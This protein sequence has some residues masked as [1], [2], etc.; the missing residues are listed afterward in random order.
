[1]AQIQNKDF[2]EEWSS[3]DPKTIQVVNVLLYKTNHPVI[4]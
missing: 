1:M 4:Y 3:S 2:R